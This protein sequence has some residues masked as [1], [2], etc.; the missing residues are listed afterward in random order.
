MK[1][2][3]YQFK[4]D[5]KEPREGELIKRLQKTKAETGL[6]MNQL[7][8]LAVAAGLPIVAT[9]LQRIHEPEAAA[10]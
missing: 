1:K 3:P 4:L 5:P 7:A 10:A 9:N 8:A 2:T 6:S